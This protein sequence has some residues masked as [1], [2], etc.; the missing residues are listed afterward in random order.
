MRSWSSA[1]PL[2]ANAHRVLNRNDNNSFFVAQ[3]VLPTAATASVGR[4]AVVAPVATAA[5][6]LTAI[7]FN[8]VV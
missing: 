5:R 6:L 2:L 1:H 4:T 7:P 8:N 3:V